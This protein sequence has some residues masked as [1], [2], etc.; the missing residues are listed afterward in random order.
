MEARIGGRLYEDTGNGTGLIWFEV[1]SFTPGKSMHLYGHIS[2]PFGGPATSLLFLEV[3]PEGETSV[4]EI[5]NAIFGVLP[6]R[7]QIEG[8][9]SYLFNSGLKKHIEDAV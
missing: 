7:E 4:L 9:W 6:D 8:G 3:I 5:T 1:Q 2:P